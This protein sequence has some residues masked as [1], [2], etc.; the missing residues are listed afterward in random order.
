MCCYAVL[1]PSSSLRTTLGPVRLFSSAPYAADLHA[2]GRDLFRSTGNTTSTSQPRVNAASPAAPCSTRADVWLTRTLICLWMMSLVMFAFAIFLQ[3]AIGRA[4]VHPSMPTEPRST[5]RAFNYL[6][7]TRG[8]KQRQANTLGRSYKRGRT[9][10][11][12]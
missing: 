4:A 1:R 6:R 12:K 10:H 2:G 8:S 3:E 9:T 7:N 11:P 5:P